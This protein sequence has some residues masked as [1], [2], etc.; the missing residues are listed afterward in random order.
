MRVRVVGLVDMLHWSDWRRVRDGGW[1]AVVFPLSET[2]FVII[3]LIG[4]G[5]DHLYSCYMC[6]TVL[7]SAV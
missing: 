1:I 5:C 7:V 2:W 3:Q 4:F 6:T